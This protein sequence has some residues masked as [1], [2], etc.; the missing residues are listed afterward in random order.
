LPKDAL[1][2]DPARHYEENRRFQA[3]EYAGN[4][5]RSSHSR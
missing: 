1:G 5:R 3:L 4:H 2:P